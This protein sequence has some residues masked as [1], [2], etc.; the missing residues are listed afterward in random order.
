[1]GVAE[2]S[3]PGTVMQMVS[4]FAEKA[5]ISELLRSALSRYLD[6]AAPS[7]N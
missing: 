4:L 6:A 3:V 5:D 7:L 1:M 2:N